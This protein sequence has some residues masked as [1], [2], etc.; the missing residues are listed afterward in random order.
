MMR[1][2]RRRRHVVEPYRFLSP[3]QEW[4]NTPKLETSWHRPGNL[5]QNGPTSTEP[6]NHVCRK[7][8]PSCNP[9]KNC[10]RIPGSICADIPDQCR[11]FFLPSLVRLHPRAHPLLTKH[12]P[13]IRE[14]LVMRDYRESLTKRL[15]TPSYRAACMHACPNYKKFRARWFDRV[16]ER[17]ELCCLR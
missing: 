12:Q 17:R 15:V 1:R 13:H 8:I 3:A 10:P 11:L 6:S 7:I 16:A 4:G 9:K 5:E 2:R 14:L